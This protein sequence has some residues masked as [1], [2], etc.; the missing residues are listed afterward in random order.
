MR[1]A[2]IAVARDV[3]LVEVGLGHSG[4]PGAL[5]YES[6]S[7]NAEKQGFV[8]RSSVNADDVSEHLANSL[9]EGDVRLTMSAMLVSFVHEARERP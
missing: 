7:A 9:P 8:L 5:K 2:K 6:C 3:D 1:A 4:I